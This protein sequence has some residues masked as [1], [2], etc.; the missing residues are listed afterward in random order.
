MTDPRDPTSPDGEPGPATPRQPK[1]P[2]NAPT[3]NPPFNLPNPA[4]PNEDAGDDDTENQTSH[5]ASLPFAVG[6]GSPKTC[7][8]Q[9]FSNRRRCKV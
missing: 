4:L 7:P 2:Y 5:L 3:F 8:E 9:L 1:D 6:Y